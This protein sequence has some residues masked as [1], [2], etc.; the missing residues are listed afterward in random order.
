MQFELL[1]A[2]PHV[3]ARLKAGLPQR[4]DHARSR[5]ALL[6]VGERLFVGEVMALEEQL[7][8]AAGDRGSRRRARARPGSP[9]RPPA[10]RPG[11]RP[12][13]RPR[14]RP[15]P[16]TR[17]GTSGSAV[18]IR[19]RSSSS[20]SPVAEETASTPSAR[21]RQPRPPLPHD[22]LDPL[23]R[24]QV[25]LG[26]H[27][28][29]RQS[30]EPGAV[31]GQLAPHGLIVATPALPPAAPGRPGGRASSSARRGRGTRARARL[32]APPP[33]SSP[34]MS[35]ITAWRSSSSI[36]PSTGES[37]RERIV[38]HLGRRPGQP[39]QQRGLPRIGQ[40]DQT[41]RP[42]SSFKRSSIQ[43]ASPRGPLL[44]KPRSLP[45]RGRKPP[46]PVPPT[47]PVRDHGPLPDLDQVH[48]APIHR[49]RLRCRQARGSARSSPRA[50]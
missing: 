19:W 23:R 42:P 26:E 17:A 7:D 32:P 18:K 20:P 25:P 4:R 46:V 10:G 1:L 24:E 14:A 38:G 8:A 31:G 5:P 33:R 47:P 16:A 35:A 13:T 34:G 28:Q 9:P 49:D 15:G 2:D 43:P 12:R 44:G 21:P 27:D 48:G 3:V 29:L 6:Q 22:R 30:I 50:P 11:A 40:P 39:P 36:V 41:R 45:S 37:G